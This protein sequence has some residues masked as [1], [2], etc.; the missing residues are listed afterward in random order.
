MAAHLNDDY[1]YTLNKNYDALYSK[2]ELEKASYYYYDYAGDEVILYLNENGLNSGIPSLLFSN[3]ILFFPLEPDFDDI[4]ENVMYKIDDFSISNNGKTE[5]SI[6]Q[7][8][9]DVDYIVL[10]NGINEKYDCVY[11]I[12][13]EC[14]DNSIVITDSD[15][16]NYLSMRGHNI[17][18]RVLSSQSILG[19]LLIVLTIIP[20]IL[21]LLSS[22]FF[23]NF[24]MMKDKDQIYISYIFY[25]KKF[26]IKLSRIFELF[27]P[28]ILAFTLSGGLAYFI[29]L[30]DGLVFL[31]V[32]LIII[33]IILFVYSMVVTSMIIDKIILGKGEKYDD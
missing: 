5:T 31:S 12:Y 2:E 25:K 20:V 21:L 23:Y 13:P 3:L 28:T 15:S 16:Y 18:K 8:A 29:F 14:H 4:Q 6:G 24:E 27:I 22:F 1:V 9:I 26:F 19:N 30:G 33:G 7:V 17:K 10:D 11:R 32:P